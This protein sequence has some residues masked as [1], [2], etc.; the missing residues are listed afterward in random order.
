MGAIPNLSML[1]VYFA[2]GLKTL[3]LVVICNP[4]I[5]PHHI[6]IS[7]EDFLNRHYHYVLMQLHDPDQ[8][9]SARRR[10]VFT[11]DKTTWR[12]INNDTITKFNPLRLEGF[13]INGVVYFY[14]YT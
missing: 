1:K 9:I 4:R 2:Y 8:V 12:E 13:Y 3:R 5:L 6:I 10:W 14:I 11:L 7:A